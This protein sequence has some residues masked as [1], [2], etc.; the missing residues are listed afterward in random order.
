MHIAPCGMNCSLCLAFQ[1]EKNRCGGCLSIRIPAAS[2]QQC[3][4]RNCEMLAQTES[5]FCYDCTKYPCT[6]LKNLD[7][8]YRTKYHMSMLEN[9]AFIQKHGIE[10]FI[11]AESTRWK[12]PQ[13][14]AL[15]CIHRSV[16]FQCNYQV[17]WQKGKC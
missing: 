7:K 4:I 5:K 17:N 14:G 9:L 6:R 11:E 1:R 2:C 13:C 12:C 8:R 3:I 10:K 16:C 15:I